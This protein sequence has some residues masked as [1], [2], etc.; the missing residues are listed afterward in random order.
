MGLGRH[1]RREHEARQEE[2]RRHADGGEDGHLADA[3]EGGPGEARE[4]GDGGGRAEGEAGPD[5]LRRRLRAAG[6]GEP[7][8]VEQVRDVVEGDADEGG[9]E[10]E[11]EAVDA[12]EDELHRG[13]RDDHAAREREGAEDEEARRAEEEEEQEDD[14]DRADDGD[15]LD[16]GADEALGADGDAVDARLLED[17]LA[18]VG[19]VHLGEG[20]VEVGEEVAGGG[21]V[22]GGGAAR[23]EDDAPDAVLLLG[24]EGALVDL[25][26]ALEPAAEALDVVEEEEPGVLGGDAADE[27]ARGARELLLEAAGAGAE[28]VVREGALEGLPLVRDEVEAAREVGFV[29]GL[30]E[31]VVR[32]RADPG[33]LVAL[34]ERVAELPGGGGGRV[35]VG[36]ADGERDRAVQIRGGQRARELGEL[37]VLGGREEVRDVRLDPQARDGP[38]PE[39]PEESERRERADAPSGHGARPSLPPAGSRPRR[40]RGSG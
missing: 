36:G 14:A 20:G 3:R 38:G 34:L 28:G 19:P 5:A 15:A 13:D 25:E 16:V 21:A 17:E 40:D 1:E 12:A 31:V 6:G 39:P 10:G 4:A 11:R 8:V 2:R 27:G 26:V 9:A 22:E 35:A 18:A 24:D 29:E 33:D 37:P 7:V 30:L 32:A 23:E